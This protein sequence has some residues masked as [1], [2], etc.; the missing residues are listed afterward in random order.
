MSA[1]CAANVTACIERE[2]RCVRRLGGV[3]QVK[4][5]RYIGFDGR[6]DTEIDQMSKGTDRSSGL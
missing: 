5:C 4:L 2:T 1:G 6:T 3:E